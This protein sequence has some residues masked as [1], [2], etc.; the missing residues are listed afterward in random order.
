MDLFGDRCGGRND[1][2]HAFPERKAMNLTAIAVRF[3]YCAS[4][5]VACAQDW[6]QVHREDDAKWARVSGLTPAEVHSLWRMSSHYAN[7]A[8]DDSRIEKVD[9]SGLSSR[10]H[11]LVVTS[12]GNNYCLTLAVFRSTGK[13]TFERVWTEEQGPNQ[14]QF[15]GTKA[16]DATVDIFDGEIWVEIPEHKLD[17][18]GQVELVDYRYGW[19]GHTYQFLGKKRTIR[20]SSSRSSN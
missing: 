5:L 9:V 7:E 6:G 15:C 12:A 3:L 18:P 17:R 11:T 4:A 14:E 8:D 20:V 13:R 16:G 19:N 1:S 2:R 10:N